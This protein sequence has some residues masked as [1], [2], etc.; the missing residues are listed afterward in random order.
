M[1]KVRQKIAGGFRSAQG[2]RDLATLRSVLLSARKQERNRLE[3][4][5]QGPEVFLAALCP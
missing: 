1:M 5:L 3:T 4:L 2:A